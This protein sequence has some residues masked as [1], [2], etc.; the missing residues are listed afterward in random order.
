M[1]GGTPP[2][3]EPRRSNVPFPGPR[4]AHP[5]RGRHGKGAA[6]SSESGLT[7][8]RCDGRQNGLWIGAQ[9]IL[10][11]ATRVRMCKQESSQLTSGPLV[12]NFLVDDG[13][14]RAQLSQEMAR[15][16]ASI[17]PPRTDRGVPARTSH[18]DSR[19]VSGCAVIEPA[20]CPKDAALRRSKE[21]PRDV[22]W[23][24]GE[25]VPR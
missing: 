23:L 16:L 18:W 8:V 5:D 25:V 9:I 20:H 7:P 21:P 1:A 4:V 6:L 3:E 13:E 24:I 22:L 14:K 19:H 11:C 2:L 15:R 12:A 17:S 10:M